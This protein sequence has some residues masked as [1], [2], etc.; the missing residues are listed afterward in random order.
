MRSGTRSA[1]AHAAAVTSSRTTD[2]DV[3]QPDLPRARRVQGRTAAPWCATAPTRATR[4]RL[5][6]IPTASIRVGADPAEQERP[7]ELHLGAEHEEEPEAPPLG[8]V[9]GRNGE[10]DER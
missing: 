2:D 3:G 1:Q 5:P 6:A 8:E 4:N 7:A 9:L 10:V